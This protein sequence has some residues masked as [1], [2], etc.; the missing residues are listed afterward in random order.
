MQ[1][2]VAPNNDQGGRRFPGGPPRAASVRTTFSSRCYRDEVKADA[3]QP[4]RALTTGLEVDLDACSLDLV[5]SE[6]VSL[7]VCP[8]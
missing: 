8:Y 3:L 7:P 4:R 1:A 2:R 5:L 6:L